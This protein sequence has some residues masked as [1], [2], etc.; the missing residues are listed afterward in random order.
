MS[1]VVES[2]EDVVERQIA[3]DEALYTGNPEP[4]IAMWSTRDPVTL[5]SAGG[6][7]K[8]GYKEITFF[9]RRLAARYS[10][11]SHVRFEIE[12]SEL[13]GEL[14]YTVGLERFNAS[15][16]GAPVSPKIIRATQVYRHEDGGWKIVHRHGDSLASP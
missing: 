4:R 2:L 11:A 6:E 14:A 15:I 1:G 16:G 8:S 10:D 7:S 12:T 5:F 3:A 13:K 9:F